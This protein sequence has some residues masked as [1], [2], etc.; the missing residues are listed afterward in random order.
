MREFPQGGLIGRAV[1]AWMD[2]LELKIPLRAAYAAYF[3]VLSV[4]PALLL[5]LSC[6][7]F[8]PFGVMDLVEMVDAVLPE[9]L[10]DMAEELVYTT[11]RHATG[12]VAGLSALTALWSASKG[13]FGL[14]MGLDA[15]YG[16]AEDR[17]YLYTRAVSVLYSLA[18]LA[19]VLLTLVLQV[20]GNSIMNMLRGLDNPVLTSL[21]NILDLRL[22]FLLLI[23]ILLFAAMFTILPNRRNP[24]FA[25][26]PG[27]VFAAVGWTGFS[28]LYSLYLTYF[29]GYANIFGSVYGIA[30]F[31]LWLYFC[32][33][34]L[35]YGGALNRYLSHARREKRE[36]NAL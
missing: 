1:H 14:L 8:M 18:L 21:L 20:F 3:I 7:R 13:V 22:L 17:G 4:F 26:L 27:A 33:S 28:Q 30:M 9:A 25:S 19:L 2:V 31:M 29:S 24:F 15:V 36:D 12:R 34:M 10:W 35:F 16:V 23:Q 5:M 11:Y 32:L 6:I